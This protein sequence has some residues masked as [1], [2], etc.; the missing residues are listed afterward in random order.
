MSQF[1]TSDNLDILAK[2]F[3]TSSQYFRSVFRLFSLSHK[4]AITEGLENLREQG[5]KININ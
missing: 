2:T 4:T 5:Y 1:A 3:L